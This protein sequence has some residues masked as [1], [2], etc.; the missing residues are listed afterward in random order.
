MSG[1]RLVGR[2]CPRVPEGPEGSSG[3]L[4]SWDHLLL[5][6]WTPLLCPTA[7]RPPATVWRSWGCPAAPRVLLCPPSLPNPPEWWA[8]LLPPPRPGGRNS[9]R[10]LTCARTHS[11]QGA[12][13]YRGQACLCQPL[14][15]H[16]LFGKFCQHYVPNVGSLEPT[17]TVHRAHLPGQVLGSIYVDV[18]C[19]RA[20]E[21]LHGTGP[22]SHQIHTPPLTSRAPEEVRG[23]QKASL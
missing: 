21:A 14:R 1:R 6:P 9:E 20:E 3:S 2:P 22:K 4:M 13:G 11:W 8:S 12:A 15:V 19:V 16:G 10:L 18:C 17:G 7:Q 5:L 23:A